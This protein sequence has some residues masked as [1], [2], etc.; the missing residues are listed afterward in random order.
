MSLC[1]GA[2]AG[3]CVVFTLMARPDRAIFR[4][5]ASGSARSGRAMTERRQIDPTHGAQVE[6]DAHGRNIPLSPGPDMICPVPETPS[7]ARERR[8]ALLLK[9]LPPRIARAVTWLRRPSSVW[10]RVAVAIFLIAGGFLAILPVFGLWMFPLG[11]ALLAEDVK[12]LRHLTDRLL[13]WL[14]RRY[15]RW[16]GSPGL[17]S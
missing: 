5:A 7:Q 16:M 4:G 6:Y 11:L 8:L 2:I 3:Q 1:H 13:G 17:M 10:V 14:E 9:K 12:P 15:P